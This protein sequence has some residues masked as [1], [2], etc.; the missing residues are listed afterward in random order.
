MAEDLKKMYRTVMDDHFPESLSIRFG[1]QELVYRKRTWKIPDAKTGEVIEKGLRY[2]ENPGQEAALYELVGGHLQLGDCR[3]IDPGKGLVSAITE[4]DMLQAGKHPGKTNLTDLDNGLNILKYLM[5]QPAAVI[6]KH[7]NPCGAAHGDSLASAYHRANRADRIAA[8]GG[9]LVV[10]R[11]LDKETA[12]QVARNYLEVVAAPDFEEGTLDLLK[13]RT[14]LRIVQIRRMDRLEE[15]R[16]LRFVDFKSLMDGGLIAQQSPVCR[17]HGPEDLKLAEAVHDGTTYRIQRP[18]TAKEME[19]LLFGWYVE[20]G[21][22]SNSVLYVKDQ[23]TVAIGTGEQDRV[24]VAELAVYK[25]Y[26]N[27]GDALCFDQ[28]GISYKELELAVERGERPREDRDVIDAA[29]REAKAGLLG[30]TMVSDAFFP[31]RDGV[32]V[33]IRQGITAVVQPGGSLRDWEV[34]EACNEAG[35]TMVFTGQRAFKH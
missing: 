20:Q 15:Y 26:R 6:L 24:G 9:C 34:I 13:K 29:T 7:N 30:S 5:K 21:V 17:V 18:P 32:D 19:D 2:G 8:F 12:E 1:D 28:Y 33:G 14:N 31:F 4:A 35:V 22:T 16:D 23:C 11:P 3:F 10:N 25:A 27:Y